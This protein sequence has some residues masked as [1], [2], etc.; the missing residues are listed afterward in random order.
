LTTEE[1]TNHIVEWV[2]L[3]HGKGSN[4]IPWDTAIDEPIL[5]EHATFKTKSI[6]DWLLEHWIRSGLFDLGAARINGPIWRGP[7]RNYHIKQV[8]CHTV[9]C[10]SIKAE[11]FKITPIQETEEYHLKKL[12]E[13][14]LKSL[15]TDPT[16]G[17]TQ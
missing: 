6:D 4:I 15:G 7:I 17:R 3:W 2:K 5:G 11:N 9:D 14:S 16:I 10:D 12:Y 13:L 1:A 8:Y